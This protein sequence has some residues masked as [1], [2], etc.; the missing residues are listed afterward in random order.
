MNDFSFEDEFGH[1]ASQ[2]T[3]SNPRRENAWMKGLEAKMNNIDSMNEKINILLSMVKKDRSR[4][5][6]DNFND[7]S[8]TKKSVDIIK[9]KS[10]TNLTRP[11]LDSVHQRQEENMYHHFQ[12]N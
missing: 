6:F 7:H 1:H 8:F 11:A 2:S 4:E 5:R 12:A 9:N 3:L 10:K